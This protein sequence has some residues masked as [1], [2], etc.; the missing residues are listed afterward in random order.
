[1]EGYTVEH[2]PHCAVESAEVYTATS[3]PVQ[4]VVIFVRFRGTVQIV[5]KKQLQAWLGNLGN[6]V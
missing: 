2:F 4:R 6:S 5:F 3:K 1:M